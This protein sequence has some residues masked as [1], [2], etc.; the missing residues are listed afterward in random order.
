MPDHPLWCVYS[1]TGVPT[2]AACQ[3]HCLEE[4][5]PS[6]SKNNTGDTLA[7]G[8]PQCSWWA[9]G[10]QHTETGPAGACPTWGWRRWLVKTTP[11]YSAR[12]TRPEQQPARPRP[13]GSQVS[14]C[15]AH[16]R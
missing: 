15:G 5:H 12:R 3:S 14:G 7:E 10:Y 9:E 13:F 4:G 2:P 6:T 8:R 1:A 11:P 16:K